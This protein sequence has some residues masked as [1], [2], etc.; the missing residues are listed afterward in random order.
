VN[1]YLASDVTASRG[2]TWIL[3]SVYGLLDEQFLGRPRNVLYNG[4]NCPTSA[5]RAI[6]VP[7]PLQTVRSRKSRASTP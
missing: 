4:D 2:R 5:L 1:D 7:D 6:A 3:E